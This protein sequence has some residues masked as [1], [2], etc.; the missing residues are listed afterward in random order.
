KR[1]ELRDVILGCAGFHAEVIAI[2]S[3]AP[4]GGAVQLNLSFLNRSDV[5]ISVNSIRPPFSVEDSSVAQTLKNNN[6]LRMKTQ[7]VVPSTYPTSQPYWLE[8]DQLT[9]SY[10]VHDQTLR[11]TPGNRPVTIG[12]SVDVQGTSLALEVPIRH[13]WVDRVQGELSRPFAVVPPVAVNLTE[14]TVVFTGEQEKEIRLVVL[15]RSGTAR[16]SVRLETPAG[17]TVNPARHP[18]E[19]GEQG[20]E[21]AAVFKIKAAKSAATGDYRAV[22]EL[23]GAEYSLGMVDLNYPHIDP[24]VYF[25]PAAGKLIRV[26]MKPAGGNIGYIAGSGDELPAAMRQ[27]GYSVTFL[28]DEDLEFANLGRYDAIVAGVRAYNTRPKL[29][30][31]QKRLM[32]YVRNG[33]RYV[34]QY[35]TRESG[36]SENLGP[37]PFEISRDRVTVEEAPVEFVLP[38]HPVLNTPNKITQADF[39]GWVQERGLYFADNWD[40]KYEAVLAC[41]DPREEPKRGG[42]LVAKFGKGTYIYAAYAF[43]RQLPAGVPGAYRLLVNLLSN[44]DN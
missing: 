23:G 13:K 38:Q 30:A 37:Y 20:G 3:S 42:L 22:A 10:V 6:P 16:G 7:V 5:A 8:A 32:E 35:V 40:P 34:V 36:R 39:A 11:G 25:P 1:N 28:S 27:L 24:Q 18:F 21:I 15:G 9:G 19:F 12:V 31:H 41:G 26:P 43:F 2:S 29:K 44:I 4:P 17:W 14:Q 33:G